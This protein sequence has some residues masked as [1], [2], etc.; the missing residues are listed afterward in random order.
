MKRAGWA[1]PVELDEAGRAVAVF[2]DVD[3]GRGVGLVGRSL[4]R[5]P[6]QP[7]LIGVLLDRA[8]FEQ[9]AESR[10][11]IGAVLDL[12]VELRQHDHTDVA[13]HR[14]LLE[15][16][17][18]RRDLLFADHAGIL[19]RDELQVVHDHDVRPL[20]SG[21]PNRRHQL[22][23]VVAGV[24]DLNRPSTQ[25]VGGI[26]ESVPHLANFARQ[27]DTHTHTHTIIVRQ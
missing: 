3:A 10:A 25:L 21:Q 7:R 2:G 12:A 19:G 11:G 4:V 20:A 16:A 14:H 9:V 18:R 17:T 1:V 22:A 27:L 23:D 24:V 8:R 5:S 15:L 6:E 13:V 26:V